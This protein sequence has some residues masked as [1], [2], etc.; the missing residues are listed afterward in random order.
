MSVTVSVPTL[1]E[2][3]TEAIV[4]E[5]LKK[6]GD[7]VE[8][9]EVLVELETDKIT[10]SVPA[11]VAGFIKTLKASAEDTV[12][13][14]DVIAEIEPGARPAADK[15]AA[16]ATETKTQ[17]AP[18]PAAAKNGAD[19]KPLS[20]AVARLVEENKLDPSKIDATGPGGRILKGDVLE[21]LDAKPT[22]AP[23]TQVIEGDEPVERVKMTRLRQ[24][25]AKRLVEAQQTA[26]MLTTF[27]EVDMS[28]VMQLRKQYQ[29]QFVKK[30]GMKLGF[31]SFFLKATVEALKEYPAVNAEIDGDEIVY[32][33]FYH[34]GVAVGGG[35][36]LVVPVVR[37]ADRLGF[38]EV[39]REISRLAKLAQDNKLGLSDLQGGT[40]TISNGGIY[41]SMMSTPILNPPQVGILG[42]HN[43]TERAVVINGKV[44]VRPMMYL[45]LSYDHRI[46]DGKE[47]VSFL[48]RIKECIENPERIL[49]EI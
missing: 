8:Q 47:A 1:G 38:A 31:M 3:V 10:V 30:Y 27:N 34:I 23:S 48:V 25:V 15:P 19:D 37:H 49:L 4:S 5:W 14:G 21:H 28:A 18:A 17:D 39:E 6:E 11:P 20:P 46:I 16:K 29:D 24:T 44:E 33:N 7:F 42:M 32:K 22:K 40:F 9:D 43:I 45:A 13:V 35:K 26:A 36:G 12:N 41:G 2:S